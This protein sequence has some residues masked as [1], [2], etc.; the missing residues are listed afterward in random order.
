LFRD[1][2][3]NHIKV[4]FMGECDYF[5]GTAFTWKRLTDGHISVHLSQSAFTE[6]TSHRFGSSTTNPVP[7]MTLYR[8]GLPIDSIPSADPADPELNHRTKMY[9]SMVGSINWLVT[10]T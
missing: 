3:T 6:F 1:E 8:S 5:L 7:N 9:Q 4:N 10:G 2:L